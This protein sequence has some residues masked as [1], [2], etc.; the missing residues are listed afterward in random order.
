MSSSEDDDTRATP[1]EIDAIASERDFYR[2]LL[3][4]SRQEEV[5]PLLDHALRLIVE[6]TGAKQGYLELHD[7]EAD[8]PRWWRGHRCNQRDLAG[9]RQS[10]SRGII[11]EA[12]A[13]GRT[14][15]TGAATSDA[16]FENL[17]SVQK[18]EI[19][20]ALC[21][22]IGQAPP[23]GVVYLQGRGHDGSFSDDDRERAELF[24]HQ[25]AAIA[26]RLVARRFEQD[27]ID[28][29]RAA[30]ARFPCPQLLGRSAAL[31]N[32]LHQAAL[33]APL[34][35]DVL[36]TGPSGTGKSELAR[37]IARNSTRASAPFVELNCAAIPE[38]LLESEL[39]GAEKGAFS[40]A[41]RTMK[42]K[43]EE[44]EG[45][46][47]FLDEIAELSLSSQAKLLQLLQSRTYYRLGA[48]RARNADIRIIS[49][50]NADLKARVQDR[51]F[52]E[53]LF[54]RL[55]VLPI[56]IPDLADRR[57]DIPLLMDHVCAQVCKDN[58]LP[59]ITISRR[60]HLVARES[61]WPGNVR[62]LANAV[63]AAV[64]RA[65]GDHATTVS[66]RHLFP[67]KNPGDPGNDGDAD[68]PLTFQEATRQFQRR[69]LLEI[70]ERNDWNI[71]RTAK[72]LDLGRT[73]VYNLIRL[74]E[75]KGQKGR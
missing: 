17:A 66:P 75:L 21:A 42:G 69:Y 24:A 12:I 58:R 11:A 16:R 28:H 34:E 47:L 44:A 61:P 3:D 26:D 41:V 37:A 51:E 64:I 49:A 71:S 6:V 27:R 45:G 32:V 67:G 9:I 52:R 50:T 72:Q 55:E 60:A 36:I 1:P 31:A 7:D 54:F 8:E 74:H 14:V 40:G 59:T 22:P 25:L 73:H 2:R 65:H 48:T 10:I 70:L 23:I 33:V 63:K 46:T 35:I 5:E 18:N 68:A 20:A 19:R 30:R 29:T 57:D 15:S 13:T 38:N 39:F 53:D 56:E 4:L 43:V 62:Q